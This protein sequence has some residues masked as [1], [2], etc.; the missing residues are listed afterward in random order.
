MLMMIIMMI[1]LLVFHA[2]AAAQPR[3]EDQR[4]LVSADHRLCVHAAP[5][6]IGAVR[7]NVYDPGAFARLCGR[8]EIDPHKIIEPTRGRGCWIGRA[9]VGPSATITVI[10]RG[11]WWDGRLGPDEKQAAERGVAARGEPA[12]EP[13]AVHDG[14]AAVAPEREATVGRLVLDELEHAPAHAIVDKVDADPL[15][16]KQRRGLGTTAQNLKVVAAEHKQGPVFDRG[17]QRVKPAEKRGPACRKPP[18]RGAHKHP[19]RAMHSDGDDQG[20]WRQMM[21]PLCRRP[22]NVTTF[23]S[24]CR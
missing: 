8:C 19:T 20:H 12:L 6:P 7:C 21:M 24:R 4:R 10:I 5:R 1:K 14:Q 22:R 18:P 17:P 16:G 23:P 9:A 3:L 11:G 2:G 15:L 13:R